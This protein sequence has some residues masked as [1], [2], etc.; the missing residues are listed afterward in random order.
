MSI[1]LETVFKQLSK[2]GCLRIYHAE[3]EFQRLIKLVYTLAFLPEADIIKGWEEVIYRKF[4]KISKIGYMILN[5]VRTF[6][7]IWN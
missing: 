3:E 5:H 4:E 1:S 7:R 6:S 2:K